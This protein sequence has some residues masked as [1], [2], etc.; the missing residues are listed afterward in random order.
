MSDL[1][2]TSVFTGALLVMYYPDPGCAYPPRGAATR[3][4]RGRPTKDELTVA[5]K[6][7]AATS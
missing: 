5:W 4:V 7:V 2:L 6:R 3:Y 1:R